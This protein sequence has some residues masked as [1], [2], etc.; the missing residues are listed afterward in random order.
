MAYCGEQTAVKGDT[1]RKTVVTL[2]CRSWT[3]PDCYEQ[4]R[5]QLIAEAIGGQPTTFLTLTTRR[6]PRLTEEQAAKRLS[7]AWR[8]VRLRLIRHHRL[9]QLPFL[10]VM[11]R[12][13]ARW[14]HLHILLRSPWLSHKLISQ[15]MAE[16][17][18]GPVVWIEKIDRKTKAAA[19]CAKYCGK[20]AEKIGNAK[21]YWQSR[22]YDLRDEP[23]P[24]EKYPP[25][26]GWELYSRSIARM[27][28]DFEQMG[29]RVVWRSGTKFDAFNTLA[30]GPPI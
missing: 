22:D 27:A 18:D 12:T 7:Y 11:E 8:L 1:Y 30:H 21:R 24:K 9:K 10:A 6:D 26:Y 23:E 28:Q 15:W 29:F 3:C 17:A 13:K 20:C 5:R 4:R 2:K 19:Y 14:P 16:L 25:G